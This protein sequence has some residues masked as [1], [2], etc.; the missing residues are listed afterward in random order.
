MLIRLSE[1]WSG[2]CEIA[3]RA[4]WVPG[5]WKPVFPPR[6][7]DNCHRFGAFPLLAFP[8]SLQFPSSLCL[9]IAHGAPAKE[10][11]VCRCNP[12]GHAAPS[13]VGSRAWS[14]STSA[15]L[16]ARHPQYVPCL[17][18]PVPA[19]RCLFADTPC[20]GLGSLAPTLVPGWSGEERACRQPV[21]VGSGPLPQHRSLLWQDGLA[22]EHWVLAAWQRLSSASPKC[23]SEINP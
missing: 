16:Q 14:S 20:H 22:R 3:L 9:F 12:N 7:I 8:E 4:T 23:I 11:W 19:P 10:P 18:Q 2:R 13:S 17:A 5:V 21:C 15:R 1:L 6:A